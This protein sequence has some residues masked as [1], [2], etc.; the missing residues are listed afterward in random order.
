MTGG[1]VD[2]GRRRRQHFLGSSDKRGGPR[3]AVFQRF[4]YKD[5]SQ[6]LLRAGDGHGEPVEQALLGA[7]DEVVGQIAPG[8]V[9]GT[10]GNFRSDTGA[11]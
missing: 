3:G 4:A 8:E 11:A 7:L 6:F 10:S 1:T 9:G 2:Q 5:F